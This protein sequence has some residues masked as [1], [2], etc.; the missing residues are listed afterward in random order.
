MSFLFFVFAVYIF[1]AVIVD[2]KIFASVRS[3]IRNLGWFSF[4]EDCVIDCR[5]CTGFWIS[6]VVAIFLHYTPVEFLA[7]W[8]ASYWLAAVE[9]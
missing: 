6:L 9:K 4:K 3:F 8:G 1:T 5:M 2:G 7:L